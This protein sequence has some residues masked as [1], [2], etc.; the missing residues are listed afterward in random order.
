[1]R[2]SFCW[3]PFTDQPHNVASRKGRF[4]KHFHYAPGYVRLFA[5]NFR[6]M[7]PI[8][9]IYKKYKRKMYKEPVEIGNPF[10]VSISPENGREKELISCLKE[11]GVCKTIIRIPSWDKEKIFTCEKFIEGLRKEKVEV[12]LALLQRRDDVIFP[13]RWKKFLEEIFSR[14]G[15]VCTF[16]EVGH[17]WN[18]TKW[19]VWDYR[20]YLELVKP[21]VYLA[22]KYGV[23]LIGPAVIDFEFHLY[24]PLME[25]IFFDKISSL[26]Y[27]DRIGAPEKKQFGWDTSRKVALL[28]AVVDGCAGVPRDVWITEFNWPLKGT[29]KY[30]PASGKPNV[31]EK[32]QADYLVRYIVLSLASGFIERIYW[33][34]LVAPGYGLID[35]RDK[36]WRKR[37]S[38]FALKT[39]ISI[40]EGSS[41]LR[42]I[43]SEKAEIF[44]FE[45][46]KANFAVCWM[47]EGEFDYVFPR[48]IIN[49]IGRDGEEI[50]C[51]D[52]KV[53]ICESPK[54]VFL[55]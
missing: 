8:L 15:K 35:N 19:G 7:V 10:G 55:K 53:R 40:I 14:F 5:S 16:F 6:K 32:Q 28:K 3:N 44:L 47:K 36:E 52:N 23:R 4:R 26:L 12:T 42:K 51:R 38:F 11:T 50:F 37:P 43:P 9:S 30:S 29:G 24:P 1:M 34:Q 48:R 18:R 33:W 2:D 41:F 27:V 25:E 46:E 54:Y 13:C 20:E 39:L 49:V 17:A 22:K 31:T 45:K 21:A